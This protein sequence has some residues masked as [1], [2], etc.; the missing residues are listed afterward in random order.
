[1]EDRFSKGAH[2]GALSSHFTAFKVAH[3]FLD[4]LCTHHGF[5]RSLVSDC[6]PIFLSHFWRELFK[7]SGTKLRISTAYH[8]K[9][10]GQTEV[11]NRVLEQYLR[12]F[13]HEKP[14]DWTKYLALAEWSYNTSTRSSTG[15]TPFEVTYGKPPPSIPQYLLGSSIIE[16]VDSLLHSR[17]TMIELMQ[18]KLAK[19]QEIMKSNADAKRRDMSCDV[20][21]WVYV[22]LQPHR[23][24]SAS[25]SLH[26]KLSKRFYGPF[27][28]TERIGQVAYKLQLP[29]SSK[30]HHVFHC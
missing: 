1:M 4:L 30:I 14:S 2:F 18:K 13:V 25:G 21:D 20:G 27:L 26:H 5:P 23:Q 29:A 12:S 7:L 3:L 11:L 9:M 6:D 10:D 16:A 8:P 19:A 22:K 15:L 17:Q 28:V 24:Q